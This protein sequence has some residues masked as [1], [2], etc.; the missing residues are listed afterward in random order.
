VR[1]GA[2]VK[3]GIDRPYNRVEA[4]KKEPANTAD[5]IDLKE[6]ELQRADQAR[7]SK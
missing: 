1:C 4:G 2:T 6:E 7:L 5:P 3:L